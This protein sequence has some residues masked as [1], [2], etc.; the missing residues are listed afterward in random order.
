MALYL[1]SIRFLDAP[2]YFN[3]NF[4]PKYLDSCKIYPIFAS[5]VKPQ[6]AKKNEKVRSNNNDGVYLQRAKLPDYQV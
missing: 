6:T 1:R 4:L 3:V 5:D 2:F